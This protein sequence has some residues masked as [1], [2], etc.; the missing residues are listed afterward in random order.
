MNRWLKLV[1]LSVALLVSAC[2]GS[3]VGPTTQATSSSPADGSTPA[4]TGFGFTVADLEASTKFFVDVLGAKEVA[5]KNA[6]G[7]EFEALTGIDGAFADAVVL[8]V[9]EEVVTL[10]DYAA[11]GDPTRAD[12]VSNDLDFQHLALVVRDM[13]AAHQAV[14]EAGVRPVSRRGPQRI[15]DSNA[16]AAGIRAFYFRDAEAH[17]L[18]LIWFPA[19]KGA[20]RWHAPSGPL[21]L[22][23]D[24]SA[25]AVAS[26]DASL[27]FYRDV[28]GLRVAG[29]SLNEG[30]EQE[31]LSGVDGARVRITGLRGAS[32]PGVEFLEY[33]Q[34]GPGRARPIGSTVRDLFH[35]ETTIAVNDIE[36]TRRRLQAAGFEVLSTRPAACDLCL[37]EAQALLVRDPDGHA[38]RLVER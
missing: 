23:I 5:R 37:V 4:V 27:E 32:G 15:P 17:P 11:Q 9:G 3:S 13:D 7:A 36:A 21:V 20:G 19:G 24:H 16:A 30:V 6:R 2:A 14:V 25:I 1:A 18:E 33:L 31:R 10:T 26:T 29:N 28:I 35:W 34:P 38:V 22:G 12:A 8:R